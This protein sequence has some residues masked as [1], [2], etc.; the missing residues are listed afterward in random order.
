MRKLSKLERKWLLEDITEGVLVVG[1]IV[2]IAFGIVWFGSMLWQSHGSGEMSGYIVNVSRIGDR[3]A[4]RVKDSVDSS[5][6]HGGCVASEN[7]EEFKALIGE[8]VRLVWDGAFSFAPFWTECP[9]PVQLK[10]E[11]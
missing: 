10:E 4:I 7:E 5:N 3:V 1:V 8:K 2:L 9:G 6:L 11:K